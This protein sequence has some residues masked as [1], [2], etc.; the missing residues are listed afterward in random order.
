MLAVADVKKISYTYY[1]EEGYI[2]ETVLNLSNLEMSND[3]AL[4]FVVVCYGAIENVN[5]AVNYVKNA[6]KVYLSID[7]VNIYDLDTLWKAE[8]MPDLL[9]KKKSFSFRTAKTCCDKCYIGYFNCCDYAKLHKHLFASSKDILSVPPQTPYYSKKNLLELLNKRANNEVAGEQEI[10]YD[11]AINYHYEILEDGK[12]YAKIEYYLNS[13]CAKNDIS[14]HLAWC[15]SIIRD[16]DLQFSECFQSAYISYNHPNNS[17][18]HKSIYKTYDIHC[19]NQFVL[20]AEWLV[21]FS[22]NIWNRLEEETL[23]KLSELVSV[24]PLANGCQYKSNVD[25]QLFD[26]MSRE[27][28]SNILTTVI[29]PA[30]GIYSWSEL[31]QSSLVGMYFPQVV[32]VY[33]DRYNVDDPTIVFSY[34]MDSDKISA[35]DELKGTECISIFAQKEK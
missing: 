3:K 6:L 15:D 1:Y 10:F 32:Y 2:I 28:I 11:F 22:N 27:K 23:Q 25:I 29:M 7:N 12:S 34:N 9:V 5:K 16:L 24:R 33:F 26:N 13:I 20:G 19:L 17:V 14:C 8:A 30:F 35:L 31:C 21:Y 4:N 18:L